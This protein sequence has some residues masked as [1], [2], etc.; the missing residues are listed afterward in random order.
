[1]NYNCTKHKHYCKTSQKGFNDLDNHNGVVSHLQ[2]DIMECEVKW[3]LGSI[4]TKKSYK[5]CWNFN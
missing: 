1:M 2:P 4:A 3:V 5:R